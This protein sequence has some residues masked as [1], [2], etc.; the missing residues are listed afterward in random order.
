ML[1]LTPKPDSDDN[2]W[3]H[4]Y[5]LRHKERHSLDG[6][7]MAAGDLRASLPRANIPSLLKHLLPCGF[8]D[9]VWE[10]WQ[11]PDWTGTDFNFILCRVAKQMRLH[12]GN[13][14]FLLFLL[15]NS[16]S[17]FQSQ[18]RHHSSVSGV[19]SPLVRSEHSLFCK[20]L[21]WGHHFVSAYFYVGFLS[22]I[23][24]CWRLKL[25]YHPSLLFPAQSLVHML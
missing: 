6:E 10:L 4:L 2:H 19:F 13:T 18:L 25:K 15:I 17:S 24:S 3:K 20:N 22:W 14:P 1:P 12:V 5:S 9:F 11:R 23:I 8:A 7:A 21:P 16:S